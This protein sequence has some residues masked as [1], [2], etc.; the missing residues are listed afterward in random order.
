VAVAEAIP[1]AALAGGENDRLYALKGEIVR[2]GIRR[3]LGVEMPVNAKR[4]FQRGAVPEGTFA[5]AFGLAEAD[6]RAHLA[7][8]FAS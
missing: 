7:R 3:L 1:F 6:Y 2:R 4:R 8:H 5:R